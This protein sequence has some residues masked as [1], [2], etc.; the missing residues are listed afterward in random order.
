MSQRERHYQSATPTSVCHQSTTRHWANTTQLLAKTKEVSSHK[1]INEWMTNFVHRKVHVA[2]SNLH[3]ALP[4]RLIVSSLSYL[5]DASI[6]WV[7]FKK[8]PIHCVMFEKSSI[9]WVILFKKKVQFFESCSK[10][11]N[12]LSHSFPKKKKRFNSLSHNFLKGVQFFDLFLKSH[13]QKMGSILWVVFSKK[14]KVQ[15]FESC[16][17]VVHMKERFNSLSHIEKRLIKRG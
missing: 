2:C 16:K 6:L 14:K 5:K 8:G 1:W 17:K 4:A 7:M 10:R 13:I 3:S 12:S 11:F 15:F 9:L